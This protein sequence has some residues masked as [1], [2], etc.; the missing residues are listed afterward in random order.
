MEVPTFG[1]FK[2][3]KWKEIKGNDGPVINNI[4]SIGGERGWYYANTLWRIRGVM[5][6]IVGGVGL[7]RGRTHATEIYPGDALDFWRVLIADK[8]KKRL[9]LFAE[10]KLPGE[11]WLEFR[12]M[13]K[14]GKTLLRQTATFRPKGLWG[15]IY[16]YTM[17]P[18]HYF[19]FNG[20]ISNLAKVR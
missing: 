1:C 5:D 15:R 6:K 2:D 14:N 20:M 8:E 12:I 13:K 9:L 19:I 4:W 7:R 3:V 10:M 18:F 16:W 17:L 11:A